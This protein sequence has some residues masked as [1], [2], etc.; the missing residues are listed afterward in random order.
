[1]A[2]VQIFDDDPDILELCSVILKSKGH[3]TQGSTT[4]VNVLEKATSFQPD[5]ILM[6][7]WIPETGGVEATLQLKKDPATKNIPVIFF[8]AS[9]D[10][11]EFAMKAKA[12]YYLKKPF[13]IA[14]L[15]SLVVNASSSNPSAAK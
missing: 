10:V 11:R 4:C 3:V 12:D 15:Q 13:N 14:E 9:N 7:N 8:S 5:V 6:D 2:R 1:M